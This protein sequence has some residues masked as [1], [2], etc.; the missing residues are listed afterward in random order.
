MSRKSR[1]RLNW[2][3][4]LV[5][6]VIAGAI[7]FVGYRVDVVLRYEWNWGAIPGYIIRYDDEQQRWV[8]NLLMHGFLT[9]IRLSIW[10]SLLAA[11]IGVVIGLC[12]TTSNLFL[13]MTAR[14]YVE[15]IRNIPP[16]VFLFIFYFF[17]SSQ[18]MPLLNL[19]GFIREAAP[20]TIATIEFLFGPT[21]LLEPLVA[22]I[23]ALAMFEAAYVAEIVRAGVQSIHRGQWEAAQAV[24]LTRLQVL[25]YVILPQAIKRVVPPLANQFISLI[26][27]SSIISLISIQE[28]TFM[29][30]EVIISTTRIF[31]VWITTAVFLLCDLPGF[32]AVVFAS[33]AAHGHWGRDRQVMNTMS[34]EV[35]RPRSLMRLWR[36]ARRRSPIIDTLQF[37]AL[38]ALVIWLAVRGA[39]AMGYR[40]QWYRVP[41][42]I[43][44]V[45]DGDLIW[46]PLMKGLFVTLE[47]T[48]WSVLL[49]VV[50]G[51][52]AALLRLAD[53][54]VSRGVARCY[55]ELIRNTPLLVQLFL[56]F[57]ILAPI[58]GMDRFWTGVVALA[59]FEGAHAMEIFRAG[60]QSVPRGQWEAARSIGLGSYHTYRHVVM[61]Q[62]LRLVLPPLTSL[63]INLIKHSAIVSAI[64][65]ADLTTEGRKRDR[66]HVPQLRDLVHGGRHVPGHHRH[67]VDSR[68]SAGE[69]SAR[70]SVERR[71]QVAAGHARGEPA[72]KVVHVGFPGR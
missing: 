5:L 8:G 60:I 66:R 39:D 46:G 6:A 34:A 53:S 56:F 33:G 10:A 24:G 29:A 36:R 67:A 45:I 1:T 55:L 19:N 21:K 52:I 70:R 9:T 47:L 49:T 14:A 23:I 17:I 4:Y 63:I 35:L 57:Y 31:E 50:I 32:L 51:V 18:I 30:Q 64:A 37:A 58:L 40:W 7:V 42:L 68:R 38:S 2:I 72:L 65:I 61:P 59:F 41:K 69:T 25:R 11:I 3:D 26:K 13:R 44:R 15:L 48:L 27:D 28:L 62:A 22:G 71:R 12:R 43:Y 54:I 20:G 16:L